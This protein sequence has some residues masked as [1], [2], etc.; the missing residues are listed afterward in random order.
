MLRNKI[1]FAV[2]SAAVL[3]AGAAQAMTSVTNTASANYKSE[4]GIAQTAVTGSTNFG[5]SSDP[6]LSVVKTGDVSKGP[7]GTVVTWQIRVSY[8]RI[9]DTDGVCGD[10]S[11][12]Q[13]V[14]VT[15]PIPA[16]FT[17]NPGTIKVSVNDGSTFGLAG[18]DASDS[19][20]A[21]GFDVSE[22][23]G[24]VTAKPSDFVEGQGDTVNCGTQPKALVVEFQATR[25]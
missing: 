13:S 16:G 25:N 21:S 6:V 7:K 15:D 3:G 4:T 19:V 5:V 23:S 18:T 24:I 1:R 8:P 12:A 10:D 22:A 2:L 9:A 11:K 14:V 20:D 17:Y